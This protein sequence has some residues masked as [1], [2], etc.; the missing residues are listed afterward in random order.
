MVE[1]LATHVVFHHS[2]HGVPAI[3]HKGIGGHLDGDQ[4]QHHAAHP[5]NSRHGAGRPL[6]QEVLGNVARTQ[7]QEQRCASGDE[8]ADHDG[9]ERAQ[10]GPIVG[11]ELLCVGHTNS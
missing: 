11:K 5:V 1:Q 7:G 8:G 3:V 6:G 2:A 9:D 10:I 4:H